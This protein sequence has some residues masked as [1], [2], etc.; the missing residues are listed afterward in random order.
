MKRIISVGVL[1]IFLSTVWYYLYHPLHSTVTI[2]DHTFSVDMAVT[3]QEKE[4]GLGYRNSLPTDHGMLF[5][6]DH[7]EVFPFWMKGMRFPIDIIWIDQTTIV[8]ISTNI[9]IPTGSYYPIY[10]PR[11]PVD[12]VL[13]VNAGLT[14]S[15]VIQ[16]GDTVSFK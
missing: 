14:A 10:H 4:K 3:P 7:K 8:D 9:P 1:T 11:T 16:I 2:N 5:V 12:K 6:W 13:E 15:Y